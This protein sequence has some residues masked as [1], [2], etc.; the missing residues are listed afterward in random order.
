MAGVGSN[1]TLLLCLTGL[2][3]GLVL[4]TLALIGRRVGDAPH[5]R[6]CGYNLTGLDDPRCP[7]CGVERSP[8][9]V[10]RG[11]RR[12]RRGL[13]ALGMTLTTPAL[14]GLTFL[15][16][17]RYRAINVYDYYPASW[18]ITLADRDEQDALKA[19]L[20]R[21]TSSGL[22]EGERRRLAAV[23]LPHN[24][25]TDA[26]RHR[27]YWS[28]FLAEMELK[29]WL[30]KEDRER[31]F[32]QMLP[33][34]LRMRRRVRE[35]EPVAVELRCVDR[36]ASMLPY[37]YGVQ[38]EERCLDGKSLGLPP[39]PVHPL[40][41]GGVIPTTQEDDESECLPTEWYS[42][43]SPPGD[44]T[45]SWTFSLFV[46]P[47]ASGFKASE[48]F[49]SKR[50]T[51]EG[52][53]HVLSAGSPDPI[54]FAPD[55]FMPH[56]L[57]Y[58]IGEGDVMVVES[59][60]LEC[61]VLFNKRFV[62]PHERRGSTVAVDVVARSSLGEHLAGHLVINRE[63]TTLGPM[64]RFPLPPER[65][66]ALILRPN[67]DLVRTSL[68]VYEIWGGEHTIGPLRV[69]SADQAPPGSAERLEQMLPKERI[70]PVDPPED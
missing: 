30:T 12:R 26:T 68:D 20:R 3:T 31:F 36:G 59:G 60:T 62:L 13:L 4:V 63:G 67:P 34:S 69:I 41:S 55:S 51:V 57:S 64:Q 37:G 48:A 1:L 39:M 8:R 58:V 24:T 21:L 19:L 22:S 18:L 40:G 50:L 61:A 42:A 28:A 14:A 33:V 54:D 23:S 53:F 47:A 65:E 44:H 7:E 49:W 32:E 52:T 10:R 17:A 46:F 2:L 25:V 35:G 56:I 29:G 70:T 38:L 16:V 43:P 45:V 6:G 11:L 5:C 27:F 66:V 9:T 15:V